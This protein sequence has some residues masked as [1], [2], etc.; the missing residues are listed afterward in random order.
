MAIDRKRLMIAMDE[1]GM[2][3]AELII[4]TGIQS[5]NISQYISGKRNPKYETVERIAKALG[6]NTEWLLGG[7]VPMN[8][9][10]GRYYSSAADGEAV[11]LFR[12]LNA[13]D[14]ARIIER[15]VTLLEGDAYHKGGSANV[16]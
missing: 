15:M 10:S 11:A 6:V 14:K 13:E 4:A 5:S 2:R 8:G 1:A 7:N 9:E 12:Q 16:G 3:Q